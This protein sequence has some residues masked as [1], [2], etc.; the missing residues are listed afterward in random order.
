MDH[1]NK[2][3]TSDI[4]GGIVFENL[5]ENSTKLSTNITYKIRL[6]SSKR[7]KGTE[8]DDEDTDQTSTNQQG[9]GWLTN[10]MYPFFQEVGPRSPNSTWGGKPGNVIQFNFIY[11]LNLLKLKVFKTS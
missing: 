3:P 2:H 4:L 5:I 1:F 6:S 8:S 11:C 9:N 10:Q 7:N